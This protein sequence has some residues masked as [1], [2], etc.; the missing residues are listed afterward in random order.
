MSE[1]TPNIK[2]RTERV[3][4]DQPTRRLKLDELGRMKLKFPDVSTAVGTPL[5]LFGFNRDIRVARSLDLDGLLLDA[6][7]KELLEDMGL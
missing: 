4:L 5:E 1:C 2:I 3:V 6:I 7:E